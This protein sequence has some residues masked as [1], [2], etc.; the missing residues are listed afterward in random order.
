MLRGLH[1]RFLTESAPSLLRTQIP[2]AALAELRTGSTA[3]KRALLEL[4]DE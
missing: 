4:V 1:T 3:A 2:L